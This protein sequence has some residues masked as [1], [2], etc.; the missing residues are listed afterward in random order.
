MRKIVLCILVLVLL[1]SAVPMAVTPAAAVYEKKI[2]CD[3]D[4]NDE[5]TKEEL[6]NAILPYMLGEGA[7]TLDEL[8]DAAWVYAYWNGKPKTVVDSADRIVT[9][10]KPVNRIVCSYE[11]DA[12]AIRALKAKEK[13]VGVDDSLTK[14]EVYFPELSKLPCI[15]T[16]FIPDLEVIIKLNPDLVVTWG[17]SAIEELGPVIDAGVTVA[18]ITSIMPEDRQSVAKL[19]YILDKEE[20]AK[21]FNDFIHE[22]KAG[23]TELVK[24][25]PED[26]KPRVYVETGWAYHTTITTYP[27][28]V[29]TLAGGRL[30]T[31]DLLDRGSNCMVEPEWV[32]KQNPDVIIRMVPGG[33]GGFTN[34]P[35]AIDDP[36][37]MKE[38]RDE[39]MNRP[40]LANVKAV[41]NERVY[42]MCCRPLVCTSAYCNGISYMAKAFYPDLLKDLDHRALLQQLITEFQ[43][44][45]FDVY[46]H[47]VFIYPPL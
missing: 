21:E 38:I 47:G 1:A 45:D 9:V 19:G 37:A 18:C 41:K 17:A 34:D 32:V 13:V 39:I 4:E 25:I 22:G 6:V 36:S 23:I 40:E 14:N 12:E 26:D 7:S 29:C 30:I 35:S 46:E 16:A 2:P 15:G 10:K 20:E 28:K 8:G 27:G 42:V 33:I 44:L 24:D 11:T 5:L 43:G 3:A 31:A